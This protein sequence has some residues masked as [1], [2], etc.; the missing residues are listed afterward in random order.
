MTKA[1]CATDGCDEKSHARGLCRRH[2]GAARYAE[3]R[4][5]IRSVQAKNR[6]RNRARDN[7][8]ARAWRLAHVDQV[9]AANRAYREANADLLREQRR[10]YRDANRDLIRALNN[11]RK[12][13]QRDVPVNDLTPTQWR[14]IVAAWGGRCAYCGCIPTVLTM[15]HVIALSRGGHHTASNV[16]PACGPCNSRKSDGPAPPFVRP[17]A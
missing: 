8:R 12:A 15:D 13:L 17:P 4:D 2:Y 9:A 7:E 11:R 16:V 6:A 1:T 14:Q 10:V 5:H 3:H